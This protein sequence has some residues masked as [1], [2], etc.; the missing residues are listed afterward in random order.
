MSKH[1]EIRS[2][3]EPLGQTRLIELVTTLSDDS[4]VLGPLDRQDLQNAIC[5]LLERRNHYVVSGEVAV[6]KSGN[7]KLAAAG[8]EISDGD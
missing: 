7:E 6:T 5:E 4:L 2:P 3:A 8:V 1:P